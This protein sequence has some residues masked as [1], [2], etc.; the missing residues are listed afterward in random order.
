MK[1]IL[2]LM[3]FLFIGTAILLF[4]LKVMEPYM[5]ALEQIP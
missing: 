4:A 1:P 2:Y 3:P 5:S